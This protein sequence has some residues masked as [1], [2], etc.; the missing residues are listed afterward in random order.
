MSVKILSAIFHFLAIA[1][2]LFASACADDEQ[3]LPEDLIGIWEITTFS[4]SGCDSFREDM[5]TRFC[6]FS[7]TDPV[8][9]GT[10]EFRSDYTMIER[11]SNGM[12]ATHDF[13]IDGV[14]LT[15]SDQED[16]FSLVYE[17]EVMNGNLN[18]SINDFNFKDCLLTISHTRVN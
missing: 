3:A 17:Y 7:D 10:L 5:E 18:L 2:L 6:D 9:C 1:C 15:I 12:E 4:I 11:N 14:S 16:T 8:D 13:T